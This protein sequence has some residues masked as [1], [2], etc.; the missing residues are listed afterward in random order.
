MHILVTCSSLHTRCTGELCRTINQKDPI[1]K[2]VLIL[3]YKQ[4]K[5]G[6]GKTQAQRLSE[7]DSCCQIEVIGLEPIGDD[8]PLHVKLQFVS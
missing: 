1:I 6:G 7:D 4:F 8:G 3:F 2:D 5:N